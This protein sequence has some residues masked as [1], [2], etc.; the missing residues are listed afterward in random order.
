MKGAR[1]L[2]RPGRVW[3]IGAGPGD[4]G[5][6]TARSL[7]VIAQAD[8]ILA[9]KLI[10]PTALDGARSDAEV[11]DVGKLG[12]GPQVPQEETHRLLLEHALAGRSVARVKGGDPFVFGRGGEEA[13]LCREH[14][15]PFEVVPGVTAGIAASAYAG[16]PVTHRDLSSAVAFVTGHENPERPESR[17]DWPALAAFP[18]TLVFY[19]G[20]KALPRIAEQLVAGGRAASEPAAV[21]QSGTLPSQRVVTGTL[22]DIAAR[23]KEAGVRPPSITVVGPVAG[24]TEEIG[25]LGRGPL[26]G[27]SVVVT[28]ARPQASGMAA[29][30]RDLG[31]RVVEAPAIRIEPVDVTLPDLASFDT[32]V[33]TSPNGAHRLFEELR[34]AGLDARALAGMRIATVGPG[35]ANALRSHGIEPDLVPGRAV[36]EALAEALSGLDVQRA[37]VARAEEA[38]EVVPDALKAAGAEVEKLVLY[39]TV[40]E[41]L[42]DR[43]RDA[44][45]GADWALFTSGSAV[46]SFTAAV[47]VDAIRESSLKLASIGP[48]TTEALHAAGLDP[49]VE[50]PEHTPSGLVSALVERVGG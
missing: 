8:V 20:V 47:G 31:A 13:Q 30:L 33:V 43:D 9:D 4:P 29:T 12:G 50:A 7:E 25:W 24:L 14:G 37:L 41:P 18:G 39:R 44:A 35:S 16:I 19:M 5:L 27:V 40:P 1:H 49:D 26:A 15:I 42:A 45:L 21:V 10:P 46:R 38:R 34:A 36:G 23:A 28:R 22:A 48:V 3:L 2:P 32:L 17:I 6:M 11:I